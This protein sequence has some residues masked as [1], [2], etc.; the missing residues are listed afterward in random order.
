MNK[1]ILEVLAVSNGLL[2]LAFIH[3]EIKVRN[4]E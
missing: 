4:D 2:P 3:I 1:L